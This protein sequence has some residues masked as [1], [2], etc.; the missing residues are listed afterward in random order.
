MK[1]DTP[2]SF[3]Q[4]STVPDS[5]LH[6]MTSLIRRLPIWSQALSSM[7]KSFTDLLSAFAGPKLNGES[8]AYY[9]VASK[10][11]EIKF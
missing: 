7:S 6:S 10:K 2:M 8:A 5:S 4:S 1:V 9:S 3:R 11:N